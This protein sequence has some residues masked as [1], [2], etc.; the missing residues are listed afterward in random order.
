MAKPRF[1]LPY[2]WTTHVT[3][4]LAGADSCEFKLSANDAATDTASSNNRSSG[5]SKNVSR[6]NA[7]RTK[8]SF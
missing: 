2:V 3:G 4:Y 7:C 6:T 8:Y 5:R 1:G